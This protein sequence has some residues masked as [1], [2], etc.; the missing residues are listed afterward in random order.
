MHVAVI[1]RAEEDKNKTVDSKKK[2]KTNKTSGIYE[3]KMAKSLQKL[4]PVGK[5][6]IIISCQLVSAM[7]Y[8]T[9][10]H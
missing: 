4:F 5:V 6:V 8:A 10:F 3:R 1:N 2:Q 9:V 7:L